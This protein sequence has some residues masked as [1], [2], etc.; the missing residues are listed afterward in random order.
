MRK[1]VIFDYDFPQT[2]LPVIE[3]NTITTAQGN[4]KLLMEDLEEI[5][6]LTAV[7]Y[8]VEPPDA[9]Y[10]NWQG[11]GSD[12]YTTTVLDLQSKKLSDGTN[13][14]FYSFDPSAIV[15]IDHNQ[16]YG[17]RIKINADDDAA[18]IQAGPEMIIKI[19]DQISEP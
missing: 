8:R 19:T 12:L 7:I 2:I 9:T 3:V 1:H 18:V 17:V 6:T 4:I 16:F 10:D 11:S 15:G 14:I 13:S 5:N